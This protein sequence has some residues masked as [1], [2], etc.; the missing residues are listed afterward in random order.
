VATVYRVSR[1]EQKLEQKLQRRP[2]KDE[3]AR[4][5]EI[6]LRNVQTAYRIGQS[7]YSLDKPVNEHGGSLLKEL[8]EDC[9]TQRPDEQVAERSAREAVEKILEPLDQRE[10]R[11][12]KLYFGVGEDTPYTLEEIGRQLS[13]T[14]E[15]VRQIKDR[16]LARLKG[17]GSKDL[18]AEFDR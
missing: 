15:R 6:D 3:V 1:L 13:L 9:E 12:L 18:L 7:N 8:I 4:E 10:R 14:R 11:V 2:Q 17:T 5:G 16:A